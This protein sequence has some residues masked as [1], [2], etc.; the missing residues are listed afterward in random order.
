MKIAIT[1]DEEGENI[2]I[3][4]DYSNISEKGQVSHF[5][6]ELE[7]IRMDLLEIWEEMNEDDD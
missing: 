6:A 3:I 2:G 1:T 7:L 4:K 5:L